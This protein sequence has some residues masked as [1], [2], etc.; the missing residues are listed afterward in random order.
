MKTSA[1]LLF[2]LPLL[3]T[4]AGAGEVRFRILGDVAMAS[5][6]NGAYANVNVGDQVELSC[7]VFTINPPPTVVAPGQWVNYAVDTATMTITLGTD[8]VPFTSGSPVVGMVDAFPVSDGVQGLSASMGSKNMNFSVGHNSGLW[9]SVDPFTNLGTHPIVVDGSFSYT[10][11][12]TGGGTFIDIFPTS[13]VVEFVGTGTNF[14]FGDGSGRTC[15]CGNNS[16]A[17]DESGCL[18]SFGQGARLRAFGNA[19]VANDTLSLSGTQMPD[20]SALYFQGTSPQSGGMG[21]VFG[22]GLRCA[23]GTIVRLG[24]KLNSAGA[25]QYPVGADAPISVR[26][27]VAAGDTRH[28]QVWYRNAADFCTAW[29]FNLSNGVTIVWNN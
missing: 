10:F 11:E 24:T 16:A 26:G 7:E 17:Q 6:P 28:Y 3:A 4:A 22:D 2:A 9:N 20:S 1:F 18:N 13:I 23:G 19:S 15:P 21:V 5:N 25:S 27:G 14:C 8:T 12:I 29:T